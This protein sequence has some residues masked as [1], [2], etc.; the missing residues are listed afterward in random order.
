MIVYDHRYNS[1]TTYSYKESEIE[2]DIYYQLS[3]NYVESV[4]NREGS[5]LEAFGDN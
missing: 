5:L 1:F 3:I 2:N 4:F